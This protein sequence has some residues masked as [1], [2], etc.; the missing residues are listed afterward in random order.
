MNAFLLQFRNCCIYAESSDKFECQDDIDESLNNLAQDDSKLVEI[1]QD[2]FLTKPASPELTYNIPRERLA[3]P[4][5][6]G[7]FKQARIVD[8]FFNESK[9]DGFFIEAGAYDGFTL[10]NSLFFEAYRGWKGLLV[11]AHP[12][13]YETL[14]STNRK[15]IN[16]KDNLNTYDV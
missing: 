14:L 8:L 2:Y 12:D 11:E 15:G 6:D 3:S 16:T 9:Y 5:I 4:M 7:Q 10:S 1:I 13:N